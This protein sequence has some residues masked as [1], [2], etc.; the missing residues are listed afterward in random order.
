M[1]HLQPPPLIDPFPNPF[2]PPEHMRE[3]PPQ[4]PMATSKLILRFDPSSNLHHSISCPLL[5]QSR[6]TYSV[7]S[8]SHAHLGHIMVPIAKRMEDLTFKKANHRW[9]RNIS[10]NHCEAPGLAKGMLLCLSINV[11]KDEMEIWADR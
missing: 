5:G 2:E 11:G 1:N 10:A 4:T 8:T 6:N 3:L 7:F 9:E